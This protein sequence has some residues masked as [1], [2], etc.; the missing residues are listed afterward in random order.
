ME[1][2]LRNQSSQPKTIIIEHAIGGSWQIF[3]E[4]QSYKKENA[5]L[6]SF[7]VTIKPEEEKKISWTER[8]SY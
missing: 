8:T 2:T 4:S 3:N 7:E 5:Y 6:I 1:V